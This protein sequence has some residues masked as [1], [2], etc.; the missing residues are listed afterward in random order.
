M[1]WF[2][3]KKEKKPTFISKYSKGD[4]VNFKYRDELYFGWIWAI[5]QKEIEGLK[6][7][8]YDIQVGGQCPMVVRNIPENKILGLKR[9]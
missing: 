9:D 2:F 7:I 4:F 8:V 1:C 3:K 5:Y 6:T